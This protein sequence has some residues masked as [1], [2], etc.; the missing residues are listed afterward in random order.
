MVPICHSLELL[1]TPPGFRVFGRQ[2]RSLKS[3]ERFKVRNLE[4]GD[5]RSFLVQHH[6]SRPLF[7]TLSHSHKNPISE[8]D[9]KRRFQRR[10]HPFHASNISPLPNLPLLQRKFDGTALRDFLPLS[11]LRYLR[12]DTNENRKHEAARARA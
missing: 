4:M 5:V 3:H 11:R 2:I 12:T 6:G 1:P 10:L 7:I 9:R 8:S